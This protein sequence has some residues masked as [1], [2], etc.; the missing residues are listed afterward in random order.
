MLGGI[1]KAQLMTG[2]AMNRAL[3]RMAHEMMEQLDPITDVVFVGIRRKGVP[4][5]Q[6]LA[7]NIEKFE[8]VKLPVGEVDTTMY[9]DDR[10]PGAAPSEAPALPVDVT[11]KVV[12][13]V[14]DVLHTGRSVRA[15]MDAVLAQGRPAKIRLAVLIDRGHRELPIRP[16]FVGKN[17]PTSQNEYIGVQMEE[18]D[19]GDG[20][21]LYE[22]RFR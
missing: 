9:R 2:D 3:V 11:G 13:R 15:A 19:G 12:V 10:M 17:V 5:A 22:G 16:D 6:R 20:V 18:I 4:L 21:A 1:P 8:H 14:D 7:D